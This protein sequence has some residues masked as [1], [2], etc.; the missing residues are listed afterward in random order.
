MWYFSWDICICMLGAVLSLLGWLRVGHIFVFALAHISQINWYSFFFMFVRDE[1]INI[2]IWNGKCLMAI[3]FHSILFDKKSHFAA[4]EKT[5]EERA[6]MK[7]G[8]RERERWP[9]NNNIHKIWPHASRSKLLTTKSNFY[10][11]MQMG[12]YTHFIQKK[13]IRN[14]YEIQWLCDCDELR[15]ICSI[16]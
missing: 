13:K 1:D 2:L 12:R 4:A 14:G 10:E 9:H 3:L 16:L 5:K 11:V 7:K 6:E 15:M 8:E